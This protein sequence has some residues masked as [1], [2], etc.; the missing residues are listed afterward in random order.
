MNDTPRKK[1]IREK[2]V[3][4]FAEDW[5]VK[6]PTIKYKKKTGI[7]GLW[8]K[9]FGRKHSVFAMYWFFKHDR[10][11]NEDSRPFDFPLKH[12]NIPVSDVPFKYQLQGNWQIEEEDIKYLYGGPLIDQHGDLLVSAENKVQKILRLLPIITIVIS[13]ISALIFLIYRIL[14]FIEVFPSA[15]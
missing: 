14:L 15:I 5:E 8:K 9:F 2:L 10:L 11:K 3:K 6:Y 12:D 1:R 13:F 4:H 7:K